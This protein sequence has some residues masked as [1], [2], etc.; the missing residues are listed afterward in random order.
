LFVV[1]KSPTLYKGMKKFCPKCECEK[2]VEDFAKNNSR[3]DG[4]QVHCRLCKKL[5]DAKHYRENKAAQYERVK[6]LKRLRREWAEGLKAAGC[7]CG[8]IDACCLEWHHP[9]K[10]KEF[11][12]SVEIYNFSKERIVREIGKCVLLCAN[13]HRKIH[14]GRQLPWQRAGSSIGRASDS[15]AAPPA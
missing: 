5:T 14:K 9:N 15:S 13:C 2:D 4:R 1:F 7:P 10:D 3:P 6:R 11:T 12:V 8:E